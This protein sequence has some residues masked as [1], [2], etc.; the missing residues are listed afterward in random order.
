MGGA[1]SRRKG[2]AFEN[3]TKKALQAVGLRA[4][5]VPL[6]GKLPGHPDDLVVQLPTRDIRV[7]AKRRKKLAAYLQ[8]WLGSCGVVVMREDRGVRYWLLTDEMMLTL[9]KDVELLRP[10]DG[11]AVVLRP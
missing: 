9:L 4:E 10:K 7:E 3:E 2:W 6:S 11:E 5:R 8:E 1:H